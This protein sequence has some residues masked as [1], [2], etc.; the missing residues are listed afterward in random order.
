MLK[1]LVEFLRSRKDDIVSKRNVLEDGWDPTYGQQDPR[2]TTIE[3]V[4]FDALCNA[5]DEFSA[6]FQRGTTL[7]ESNG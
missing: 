2:T 5:I 1:A 4:D 7:G 3:V 6:T